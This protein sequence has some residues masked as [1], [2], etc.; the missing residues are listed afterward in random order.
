MN[1]SEQLEREKKTK[2]E[3]NKLKKLYQKVNK[4]T[5]KN[6]DGLMTN[7]AFLKI[8][9]DELREDINKNGLTE[10]FVQGEQSFNRERPEVKIFTTMI[11]RYTQVMKQLM[12]VMP[13]EEQKQTKGQLAEF[14]AKKRI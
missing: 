6:L 14:L 5:V 12:E 10:L 3:I 1:I 2:Q 8:K 4:D 11:Q 7:A 13:Q 9:L